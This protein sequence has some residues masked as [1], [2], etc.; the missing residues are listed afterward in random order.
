M[1][2]NME[3]PVDF[4]ILYDQNIDISVDLPLTNIIPRQ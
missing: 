1:T 4:N 3:N 2:F